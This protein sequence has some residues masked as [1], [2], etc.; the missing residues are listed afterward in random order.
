MGYTTGREY[1][2]LSSEIRGGRTESLAD[3]I[4]VVQR[5]LSP[6]AARLAGIVAWLVAFGSFLTARSNQLS[7]DQAGTIS[8][9]FGLTMIAAHVAVRRRPGAASGSSDAS[10]AA[11]IG[12]LAV[13]AGLAALLWD[14]GIANRSVL[15]LFSLSRD[16]IGNGLLLSAVVFIAAYALGRDARWLLAAPLA[17]VA[18][19]ELRLAGNGS[20]SLA[21]GG[22]WTRFL[23]LLAAIAALVA[24][25]SWLAGAERHN[26]LLAAALITPCAFASYPSHGESVLRDIVGAA[27]LAGLV[28][29]TW[30]R[31]SPG[32]G[33]AIVLLG[34][35]EVASLSAGDRGLLPCALFAL[36]G[37]VL[38]LVG[39]ISSRPATPSPPA[40]PS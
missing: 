32:M 25:A 16:G 12:A 5:H 27:L 33:L 38:L 2:T 19:V 11:L 3:E 15:F 1:T 34:A 13:P 10:L 29:I 28:L 30:R 37:A 7:R 14:P 20:V 39:A 8:L 24:A 22:S 6:T 26:L 36:A 35:F 21:G 40:V 9:V 31:L 4:P 17:T 23:V 18:G